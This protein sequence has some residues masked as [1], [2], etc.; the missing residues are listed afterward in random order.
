M[1]R[2]HPAGNIH[3]E[4]YRDL[5][6]SLFGMSRYS[7][8]FITPIGVVSVVVNRDGAVKRFHF[9]RLDEPGLCPDGAAIAPVQEQVEAYF[10]GDR[11]DFD[12]PLA[13]DGTAFQRQVWDGLLTISFG[14][15]LSYGELAARVG[16]T[17]A[18]RAVGAANGA[19]P[20]ALIIPCHRVI[21]RDR[22]LTGF[23]GGI[24][25]KAALLAHEGLISPHL[26]MNADRRTRIEV[27]S[28][29]YDAALTLT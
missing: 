27:Q 3:R 22:S 11:R 28:L 5:F 4:D 9:G 21:G 24:P 16:R 15:T 8:S 25:I 23:G 12:L 10:A 18:F 26:A 17:G 20:I 2:D 13:P 7:G 1:A 14:Q 6:E 19:N 29:R